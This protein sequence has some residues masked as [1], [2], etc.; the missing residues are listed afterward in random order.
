MARRSLHSPSRSCSYVLAASELGCEPNQQRL[1]ELAGEA[2][3]RNGTR[4]AIALGASAA[5]I[6]ST[7]D[8]LVRLVKGEIEEAPDENLI[9]APTVAW[10]G[11]RIVR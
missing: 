3:L 11:G 7:F 10:V 8:W 5:S 2:M 4:S 1:L 6:L 9:L